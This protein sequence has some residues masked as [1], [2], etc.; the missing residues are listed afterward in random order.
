MSIPLAFFGKMLYINIMLRNVLF[1]LDGTLLPM[2]QE[3]FV[4]GYFKLL[5][6]RM[7]KRGMDPER[8]VRGL[9]MGIDAMKKNDGRKTNEERF[10]E[11]FRLACPVKEGD[12][13]EMEDFYRTDFQKVRAVCGFD[14]RA[15]ETVE[16]LRSH[17]L[18]TALATNPVFPRT[19]TESR[20]RWAGL[21]TGAFELITTYENSRYCK[22]NPLYFTEI[23]EK[24]S[25]D[26]A[27][28]L[29]VG[30]DTSD[31][32]GA[33]KA[34]MEVFI[35]TPCLIDRDGSLPKWPH[36]DF[37]ALREYIRSKASK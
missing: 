18:R 9:W 3:V 30:N 27:E 20:V 6:A 19:A 15:A 22:P 35:L 31:D 25:M 29:M 8:L 23:T 16:G 10:W 24:L 36:G 13:E 12:R 21:E 33:A 37:R 7:A 2:D 1:D 32:T 17:G 11:A 26:P 4:G 34:G 14:P 28:T 5:T